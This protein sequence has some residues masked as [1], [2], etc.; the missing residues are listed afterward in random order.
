MAEDAGRQ[1]HVFG[2]GELT[3]AG[4]RIKSRTLK[5]RIFFAPKL[6]IGEGFMD[7]ELEII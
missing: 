5:R 1:S 2:D 4:I 3:T 6:A 7:G